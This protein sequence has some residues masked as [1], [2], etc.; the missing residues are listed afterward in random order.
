[1]LNGVGDVTRECRHPDASIS[2]RRMA[3]KLV[4]L[5]ERCGKPRKQA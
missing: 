2:G 4:A 5:I 3:R 1:M